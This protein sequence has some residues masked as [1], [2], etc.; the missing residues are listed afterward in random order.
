MNAP[1]DCSCPEDTDK[2]YVNYSEVCSADVVVVASDFNI[3]LGYL[4]EM[5]SISEG[6]LLSRPIGPL[7]EIVISMLV[8][9]T[10]SDEHQL[11]SD[12]VIWAHL[13]PSFPF[14]LLDSD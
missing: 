5:K 10:V 14:T 4:T 13:T 3:E 1:I 7:T 8:L 12:K 2:C 11:L 6:E 9:T